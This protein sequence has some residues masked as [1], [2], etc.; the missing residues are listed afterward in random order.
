[1][2]DY[3]YATSNYI[4]S[5]EIDMSGWR[6]GGWCWIIINDLNKGENADE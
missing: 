3:T 4:I 2:L 1:M 6:I 5:K